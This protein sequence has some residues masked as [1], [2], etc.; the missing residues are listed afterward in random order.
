[1]ET[2]WCVETT[3]LCSWSSLLDSLKHPSNI[4]LF[5]H[6]ESHFFCLF[7]LLS[8]W[9]SSSLIFSSFCQTHA[10]QP[11]FLYISLFSF[12]SFLFTCIKRVTTFPVITSTVQHKTYCFIKDALHVK[13]VSNE[14]RVWT[15]VLQDLRSSKQIFHITDFVCFVFTQKLETSDSLSSHP[16]VYFPVRRWCDRLVSVQV[17]VPSGDGPP[18]LQWPHQEHHPWVRF[19]L[20]GGR[21]LGL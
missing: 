21:V 15:Q 12:L 14:V 17:R 19:R 9:N 5:S 18:G 3:C 6:T 11:V 8:Q 4:I 20:R 2:A 16:A 7:K 13:S 10:S 1:M